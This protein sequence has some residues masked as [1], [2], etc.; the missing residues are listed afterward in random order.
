MRTF[1]L[2]TPQEAVAKLYR[3]LDDAR[4]PLSSEVILTIHARD[5]VLARDRVSPVPLPEFRRSTVD[6]YAVQ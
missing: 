3:A 4:A 5:R 6:G 1:D 2:L